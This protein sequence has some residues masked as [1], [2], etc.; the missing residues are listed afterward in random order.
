MTLFKKKFWRLL[1][2]KWNQKVFTLP[3]FVMFHPESTDMQP[4][5]VECF[6]M[7]MLKFQQYEVIIYDV[8][9]EFEISFDMWNSLVMNYPCAKFHYDMTINNGINYIFHVYFWTN[10]RCLSI[11]TSISIT[12]LI[13][14][15]CFSYLS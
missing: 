1:L 7:K 15:K 13:F 11:M 10:G 9:A 6:S 12:P 2:Q 8:S 14:C 3:I 4:F 5:K